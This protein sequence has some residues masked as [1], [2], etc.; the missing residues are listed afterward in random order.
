ML[1]G[2]EEVSPDE[3]NNYGKT[4]LSHAAEG[5]REGVVKILLGRGEVNPTKP[6]NSGRTPLMFATRCRHQKVI[7]LLQP[8]QAITHITF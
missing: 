3:P 7:A 5:G 8:H 1:L 4:P 6:D 2:L